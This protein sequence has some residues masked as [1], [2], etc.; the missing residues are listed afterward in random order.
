M[1]V[2][3]ELKKRSLAKV[4]VAAKDMERLLANR[5]LEEAT[6]DLRGLIDRMLEKDEF[7]AL[8]ERDGFCLIHS[9]RLREGIY[10]NNPTELKAAQ[11]LEPMTQLY[12][13]NTGEILLDAAA[14]VRINGKPAYAVRLGVIIPSTSYKWK[15]LLMFLAP[16]TFA[17][18]GIWTSSSFAARMAFTAATLLV[19]VVMSQLLFRTFHQNWRDWVSVTKS[20]SSGRLKGRA[21]TKRRD[22]LGQVAFEINKMAI[23]MHNILTE[24]RNASS[25][26]KRISEKQGDM[27]RDLLAASQ[28][29]SASL[30]QISGGSAEQTQLVRETEQ[31]LKEINSKIRRAGSELEATSKLSQEAENSAVT[32]ME[33]TNT[34]LAQMQRIQHA[35]LTAES[36][37]QELE[38]QAAGIEQMIRGIREI[39]EQ[40]N[41][42]ALNAAIEAARAGEEGKGFAV[43]AD[44]VRKL[45]SRSDEVASQVMQLAGNISQKSQ[46][47]ANIIKEEREEVDQGLGLVRELQALIQILTEKSSTTAAQTI[48]ISTVMAEVLQ[49]VDY[50]ETRIEKVREISES[51]TSSAEEVAATGEMQYNATEQL[52]DQTTRLR[53]V[54]DKINQISNRFEL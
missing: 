13:R 21:Q 53:E 47:S 50:I 52:V 4:Q 18:A 42:L 8:Y 40:T 37:M 19:A 22:E 28:Q 38:R 1:R 14:P 26:T 20:I 54:S 3:S 7:L 48:R 15:I 44:E 35:S 32:G 11:T 29:L 6:S 36:S 25:S 39:A 10:F 45:A 23:G 27:V 43:V 5:V 2:S 51:F 12:T 34:L 16:V 33:K 41:L 9:N 24:L 31:T 17:L 30:Q 49:G 46:H